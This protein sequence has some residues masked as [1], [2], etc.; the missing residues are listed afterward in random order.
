MSICIT[1]K[2][3]SANQRRVESSCISSSS[4]GSVPIERFRTRCYRQMFLI[5][6]DPFL[7]SPLLISST[8]FWLFFLYSF[9][10]IKCL[11]RFSLHFRIALKNIL[12]SFAPIWISSL[13]TL[14]LNFIL[15]SLLKNFN[16]VPISPTR[17][18]NCTIYT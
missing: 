14:S 5:H 17:I 15:S 1:L 13:P 16:P 3:Q 18:T 9:L 7:N 10:L 2:P 6:I 8:I 11:V 4:R 12:F